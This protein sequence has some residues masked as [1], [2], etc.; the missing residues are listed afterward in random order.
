LA[1]ENGHIEVIRLLV[2]EFRIDTN[3]NNNGVTLLQ[4]VADKDLIEVMRFLVFKL[5]M[6]PNSRGNDGKLL[7]Y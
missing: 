4:C 1:A 2:S 5:G 3:I 7:L 6:D